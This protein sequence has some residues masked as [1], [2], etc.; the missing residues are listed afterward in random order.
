MIEV[1]SL[2]GFL[3]TYFASKALDYLLSNKE[4]IASALDAI[5]SDV[6]IKYCKKGY[7]IEEEIKKIHFCSSEIFRE[8]VVRI[9]YGESQYNWIK[10]CDELTT[11]DNIARFQTSEVESVILEIIQLAKSN[12]IL[13]HTIILHELADVKLNIDTMMN[14]G[15]LIPVEEFMRQYENSNFTNATPLSNKFMYREQ[16]I[17]D[18]LEALS[19]KDCLIITGDAGVGKTKLAIELCTQFVNAHSDYKLLC[20]KSFAT[21]DVSAYLY[22]LLKQRHKIILFID[23]ANRAGGNY[24]GIIQHMGVFPNSI[25]KIV[26]TVRAYS[27]DSVIRTISHLKSHK[28]EVCQFDE[29]AITQILRS[30]DFKINERC[31]DRIYSISK[32]NARIAI[33]CAKLAIETNN[34]DSLNSVLDLFNEYFNEPYEQISEPLHLKVLGIISLLRNIN[35]GYKDLSEKIY[36]VLEVS[37][38]EFWSICR[39]LNELE[40]VDLFENDIVK[41]SDQTL[42]TYIHYRIF[43]KDKLLPY[44]TI[45]THFLKD[46]EKINDGLIPIV[47]NFGFDIVS[48]VVSQSID[49]IWS[50]DDKET[51]QTIIKLYY[52]FIQKKALLYL[53]G[54]IEA[55]SISDID[56]DFNLENSSFSLSK[57]MVEFELLAKIAKYN[58]DYMISALELMYRIVQRTKCNYLLLINTIKENWK[59]NRHSKDKTYIY[60]LILVDFLSNKLDEN[61][62]DVLTTRI[63]LDVAGT[64]L[65]TRFNDCEFSTGTQYTMYS[66]NVCLCDNLKDLRAKYWDLLFKLSNNFHEEL[67]KLFCTNQINYS[68]KESIDIL[69]FDISILTQKLADH[70]SPNSF[71]DC[72]VVHRFLLRHEGRNGITVEIP[73]HFENRLWSIFSIFDH[74]YGNW[75]EKYQKLRL[76][77]DLYCEGYGYDAYMALYK[78]IS[79]IR[80]VELRLG[81]HSFHDFEREVFF[82]VCRNNFEIVLDLIKHLLS[83]YPSTVDMS[84]INSYVLHDDSEIDALIKLLKTDIDAPYRDKCLFDV[85][86]SLSDKIVS[87][88][89]F[90][91]L[92]KLIQ[93][94]SDIT[95]IEERQL[96]YVFKKYSIILPIYKQWNG[97]LTLLCNKIENGVT[98]SIEYECLSNRLDITKNID[99]LANVF[100][101]LLPKQRESTQ[102]DENSIMRRLLLHKPEFIIDY[103]NVLY[104]DSSIRKYNSNF[105]FIWETDNASV[106]I[107]ILEDYISSPNKRFEFGLY[108]FEYLFSNQGNV[109]N[110]ISY[111]KQ[112]L[113]SDY[114]NVSIARSIFKA[115]YSHFKSRHFEFIDLLLDLTADI[116]IFKCAEIEPSEWSYNYMGSIV[117]LFEMEVERLTSIKDLVNKREPKID[118]IEHIDYIERLINC[119]RQDIRNERRKEFISEY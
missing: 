54:T 92:I 105:C 78:D 106:I 12:E 114:S 59:I 32:G 84:Y 75:E 25:L 69:M 95:H 61:P 13:Q 60:Q 63:C 55:L 10:L 26:A 97:L 116:E 36:E 58:P 38:D 96:H 3:G 66:G 24:R 35:R 67:C 23:D 43:F 85:Y 33:M 46:G 5:L 118:Y 117:P 11:D 108:F 98:F 88:K 7:I 22:S 17:T 49:S 9:L 90:K 57:E 65:S 1:V 8:G 2:I 99:A 91:Q 83:V 31:I 37:E 30:E 111:L 112:R 34:I 68:G 29:E 16:E 107:E 74:E 113:E 52:P 72:L 81:I 47:N 45:L 15:M 53:K 28:L 104:S 76:A 109:E 89:Y 93:E 64:V 80:C 42:S 62:L 14:P 103:I 19:Q 21:T 102:T 6:Q 51:T 44:S 87:K 71:L 100:F 115:V 41:F 86:L 101:Y 39:K 40:F 73:F 20:L 50:P 48:E 79:D 56:Y 110:Q 27:Y 4:S 18:G 119:K 94:S 82:T 70:F 77:L